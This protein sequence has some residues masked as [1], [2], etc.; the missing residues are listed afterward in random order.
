MPHA[1]VTGSWLKRDCAHITCFPVLIPWGSRREL[2]S[3]V[4]KRLWVQNCGVPQF[5]SSQAKR[6]NSHFLNYVIWQLLFIS[7]G[8][9]RYPVRRGG[10]SLACMVSR[11]C[12]HPAV[13]LSPKQTRK[14]SAKLHYNLQICFFQ[15]QLDQQCWSSVILWSP[16][17][18][19]ETEE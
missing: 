18:R 5:S 15:R 16:G 13:P 7:Q 11:N 19:L 8:Q 4:E 1:P 2:D 10:S 17:E 9:V 12:K 14:K 3:A 6:A